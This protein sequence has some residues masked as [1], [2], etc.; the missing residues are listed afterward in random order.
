MAKL[1]M[2]DSRVYIAN[3]IIEEA[4]KKGDRSV[5]V[6]L[7]PDDYISISVYPLTEEDEEK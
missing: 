6:T 2:Q 5:T 3:Q 7:G 4:M 1:D